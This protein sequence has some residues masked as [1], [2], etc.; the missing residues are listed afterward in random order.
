MLMPIRQQA[1]PPEH[2]A[3]PAAAVSTTD[4]HSALAPV[5]DGP[6]TSK[7]SCWEDALCRACLQSQCLARTPQQVLEAEQRVSPASCL[8]I[9]QVILMKNH[10]AAT[11]CVAQLQQPSSSSTL[12]QVG[13][14]E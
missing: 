14:G 1:T 13:S 6:P 4:H 12:P 10:M 8:R 5:Q 3:S 2:V 9:D 11:Q 7:I